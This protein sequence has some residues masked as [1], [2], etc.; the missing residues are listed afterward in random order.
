MK[1]YEKPKLMVLS[2]SANDVLCSGC[3][4]GTRGDENWLVFDQDGDNLF[5]KAEADQLK[6]FGTEDGAQCTT[7][8]YGYCKFNSVSA[9]LLFTS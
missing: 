5:T 7:V 4:I 9:E 2:V 6:M 3:T 8:V 1:I